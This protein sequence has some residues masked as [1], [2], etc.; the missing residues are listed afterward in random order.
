MPGPSVLL[1]H[2]YYPSRSLSGLLQ[3]LLSS[4]FL[5][6]IFI[7]FKKQ[8][9][10]IDQSVHSNP[11][12]E[13]CTPYNIIEYSL[14]VTCGRSVVFPVYSGFLHQWNLLFPSHD[15]QLLFLHLKIWQTQHCVWKSI[16]NTNWSLFF[17]TYY[18]KRGKRK[19][20]HFWV[21]FMVFNATFNN[22]SAIW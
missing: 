21:R 8:C 5:K 9:I 10:L 19:D 1:S 17:K 22:I 14:S 6:D 2:L 7:V 4:T 11:A 18:S 15:R 12:Q 3:L 16:L 13:R 20:T